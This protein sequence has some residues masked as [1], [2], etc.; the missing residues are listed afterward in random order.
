MQCLIEALQ[1]N[2]SFFFE[3][4]LTGGKISGSQHGLP[5]NREKFPAFF[6]GGVRAQC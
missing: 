4:S 5:L 3:L 6:I 2:H 1:K